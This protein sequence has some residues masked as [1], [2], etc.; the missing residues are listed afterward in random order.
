MNLLFA[1]PRSC[2]GT[3]IG[4]SVPAVASTNVSAIPSR[5]IVA[6]TTA[7]LIRS[8]AIVE[9]STASTTT[10]ARFPAITMRLR[11]QRSASAPASRPKR[12]CGTIVATPAI[13]TSSGSSV[14]LATNSGPAESA[15]PSPRLLT[16]DDASSRRNGSPRRGRSDDVDDP[17][18]RANV[19]Q[20]RADARG[21]SE[22]DCVAMS[23][24]NRPSNARS[25]GL[26]CR[27][28]R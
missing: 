5:N 22:A 21:D 20:R 3:S 16:H 23:L 2:F 28:V 1:V 10:L 24:H 15:M 7:M 8:A 18:H 13:A 11:S 12:S 17:A 19:G 4:S 27:P 26:L 6:R 25:P 9:I 14:W